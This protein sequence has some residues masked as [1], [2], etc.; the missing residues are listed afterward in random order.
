[1]DSQRMLCH[2]N[3]L[4]KQPWTSFYYIG[5]QIAAHLVNV[6]IQSLIDQRQHSDRGI[7]PCMSGENVPRCRTLAS[8]AGRSSKQCNHVRLLQTPYMRGIHRHRYHGKLLIPF[9][10]IFLRCICL[11][12]CILDETTHIV[13]WLRVTSTMHASVHIDATASF[14]RQSPFSFVNCLFSSAST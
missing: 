4:D 12:R 9:Q 10:A 6:I 7:A 1:M 2:L 3:Q 13:L 14:T 5:G 8:L 11:C